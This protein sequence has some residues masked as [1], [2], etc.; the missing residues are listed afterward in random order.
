VLAVTNVNLMGV[1]SL[2][3]DLLTLPATAPQRRRVIRQRDQDL[4]RRLINSLKKLFSFVMFNSVVVT[5]L[6]EAAIRF[7]PVLNPAVSQHCHSLRTVTKKCTNAVS[8]FI[9]LNAG[10]QIGLVVLIRSVPLRNCASLALPIAMV[11]LQRQQVQR[12]RQRGMQFLGHNLVVV[13]GG[14]LVLMI[15]RWLVVIKVCLAVD[16]SSWS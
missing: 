13:F 5:T 11:R 12:D 6:A 3:Y 7:A 14:L 1:F 9:I 8:I 15:L 16:R 4:H 10:V 2:A